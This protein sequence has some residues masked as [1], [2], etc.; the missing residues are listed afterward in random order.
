VQYAIDKHDSDVQEDMDERSETFLD[1][2]VKL[3]TGSLYILAPLVPLGI[4][5]F[6][7]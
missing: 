3:T 1:H 2:L 4:D 5:W 6:F 7:T